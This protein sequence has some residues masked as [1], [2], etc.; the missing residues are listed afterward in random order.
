VV[1]QRSA[2]PRTAVQ[3]RSPPQ[4]KYRSA[5]RSLRERYY[6]PVIVPFGADHRC[7]E[8]GLEAATLGAL[9]SQIELRPDASLGY[10]APAIR[11]AIDNYQAPLC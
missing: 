2:K 6:S 3:F 5:A 1:R 9:I 7:V 10:P 4:E 8:R 11:Y